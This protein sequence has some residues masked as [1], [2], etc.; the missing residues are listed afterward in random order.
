MDDPN[1]QSLARA[2]LPSRVAVVFARGGLVKGRR[3]P[4][5]D[6]FSRLGFAN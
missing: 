1:R 3:A 5:G 6:F 2:E 4:V